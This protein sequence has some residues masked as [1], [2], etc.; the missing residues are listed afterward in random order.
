MPATLTVSDEALDLLRPLFS[1]VEGQCEVWTDP[2]VVTRMLIRGVMAY[3]KTAGMP[4]AESS[5]LAST[6]RGAITAG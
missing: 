4:F 2:E 6:L 1:K 3:G 5:A